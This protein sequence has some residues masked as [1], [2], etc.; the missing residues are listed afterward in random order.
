M[1]LGKILQRNSQQ[2]PDKTAISY[3]DRKITFTQ[4]N[5]MVN[6]LANGLLNSGLDKGD[7]VAVLMSKTPEVVIAFLAVAKA[8]GVIFPV[9][10]K[11]KSEDLRTIFNYV[12]PTFVISD[13]LYSPFLEKLL[14]PS[15]PL[16]RII[17]LGSRK[18]KDGLLFDDL[19]NK[20]SS[21]ETRNE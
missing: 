12:S 10:N 17:Y 6:R 8:R 3:R 18:R 11:L 14:R 16:T 7:R 19:L 5:E 9:N 21:E 2:Y 20:E 4:L 1:A 15:H 13:P